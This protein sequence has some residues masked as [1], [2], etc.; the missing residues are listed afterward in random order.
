MLGGWVAPG[1]QGAGACCWGCVSA[2]T[3]GV[4]V[5]P[6]GRGFACLGVVCL[7]CDLVDEV[8]VSGQKTSWESLL[9]KVQ[10]LLG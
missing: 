3:V 10:C 6:S 7:R 5:A 2:A 4:I 1:K 9:E 8:L